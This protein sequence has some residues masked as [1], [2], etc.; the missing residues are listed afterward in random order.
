MR[1]AVEAL[2]RQQ[3]MTEP[4]MVI[5]TLPVGIRVPAAIVPDTVLV[6]VP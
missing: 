6:A 5:V 4:L 2:I 1:L 3:L